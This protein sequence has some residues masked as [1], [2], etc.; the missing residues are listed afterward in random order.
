MNRF[1]KINIFI[2]YIL[3][4]ILYILG[5]SIGIILTYNNYGIKFILD[6]L[7]YISAMSIFSIIFYMFSYLKFIFIKI[8]RKITLKEAYENNNTCCILPFL[9]PIYIIMIMF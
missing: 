9:L 6:I 7:M 4:I 3:P 1:N 2:L 8:K 5:Y